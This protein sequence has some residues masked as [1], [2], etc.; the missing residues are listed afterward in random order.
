MIVRCK[1][2]RETHFRPRT[3]TGAGR[4]RRWRFIRIGLKPL[5]RGRPGRRRRTWR[6]SWFIAGKR[7]RCFRDFGQFGCGHL[8]RAAPLRERNR[9]HQQRSRAYHGAPEDDGMTGAR[10]QFLP[11]AQGLAGCVLADFAAGLASSSGAGVNCQARKRMLAA[12]HRA[13]QRLANIRERR[14]P[15]MVP[16]YRPL[17][18][19]ALV[20]P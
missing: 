3:G 15:N 8:C 17:V 11:F 16:Q 18:N 14:G 19:E 4:R 7:G 20:Q 2:L 10:H 5:G 6:C 12:H 9:Q 1:L 13:T